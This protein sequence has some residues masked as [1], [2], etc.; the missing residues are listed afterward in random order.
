MNTKSVQANVFR[1][2]VSVVLARGAVVARNRDTCAALAFAHGTRVRILLVA[3]S[4]VVAGNRH[5]HAVLTFSHG[6]RVRVLLIARLAALA[7]RVDAR[8][9]ETVVDG[10]HVL[11]VC[12]THEIGTLRKLT[13]SGARYADVVRAFFVVV[14]VHRGVGA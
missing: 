10:A 14:T 11:V 5:A 2:H 9:V 4:S 3:R 6:A 7:W 13:G 8:T 12:A 1:A